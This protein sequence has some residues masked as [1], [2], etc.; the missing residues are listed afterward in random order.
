MRQGTEVSSHC[1]GAWEVRQGLRL[2]VVC[3]QNFFNS[4]RLVTDRCPLQSPEIFLKLALCFVF[5][6]GLVLYN[7]PL[8][9]SY[10]FIL[11]VCEELGI[12]AVSMIVALLAMLILFVSEIFAAQFQIGLLSSRFL[13]KV[14]RGL[15][16]E[17]YPV[18]C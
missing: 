18:D 12:V 10:I 8:L 16:V 1:M 4:P 6:L 14:R 15:D 5:S 7:L 17:S 13:L 2:E 3:S 9:H 11:V